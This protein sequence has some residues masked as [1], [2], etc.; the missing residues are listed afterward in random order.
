[1]NKKEKG[2]L[3]DRFVSEYH[4]LDNKIGQVKMNKFDL[5]AKDQKEIDLLEEK[6]KYI[7]SRI[8]QFNK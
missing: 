2:D 5:S 7:L 6:K 4:K 3:Y 8:Q 1:M